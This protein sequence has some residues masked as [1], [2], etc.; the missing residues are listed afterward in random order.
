M[1]ESIVEK[2]T[3][4]LLEDETQAKHLLE[5]A[6]EFVHIA[7]HSY[8]RMVDE[9]AQKVREIKAKAHQEGYQSAVEIETKIHGRG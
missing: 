9:L 3:R 2:R 8:D 5:W 7:E 1:A 6:R 4:E